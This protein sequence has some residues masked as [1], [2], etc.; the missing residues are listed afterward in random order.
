MIKSF[1]SD[2]FKVIFRIYTSC[3]KHCVIAESHC[4]VY[5]HSQYFNISILDIY[6]Y[7]S[8]SKN[9]T[10]IKFI[11]LNSLKSCRLLSAYERYRPVLN[12]S[13]LPRS[14]FQDHLFNTRFIVIFEIELKLIPLI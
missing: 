4:Y 10:E 8:S 1:N 11:N 12:K 5:C 7:I 6:I 14:I 3:Q 13:L 9:G 2:P